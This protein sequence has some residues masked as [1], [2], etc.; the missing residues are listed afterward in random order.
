MHDPLNVKYVKWLGIN[1]EGLVQ[2]KRRF[3]SGVAHRVTWPPNLVVTKVITLMSLFVVEGHTR[4]NRKEA[5][6]LKTLNLISSYLLTNGFEM[7]VPCNTLWPVKQEDSYTASTCCCIT[8][9]NQPYRIM[10]YNTRTYSVLF[11]SRV[12]NY[13]TRWSNTQR[14][15]RHLLFILHFLCVVYTSTHCGY[16]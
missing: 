10:I 14:Q 7:T 13:K 5:R 12:S 9:A 6:Y 1:P 4:T 11:H 2:S 8:Q 3:E 15:L 16:D